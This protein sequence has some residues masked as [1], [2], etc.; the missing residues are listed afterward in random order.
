M[1]LTSVLCSSPQ[2]KSVDAIGFPSSQKFGR[3]NS[4]SLGNGGFST[5]S[6]GVAFGIIGFFLSFIIYLFI[7]F[8]VNASFP[9]TAGYVLAALID[10]Q[11]VQAYG[12]DSAKDFEPYHDFSSYIPRRTD[13]RESR[14][15]AKEGFKGRTNEKNVFDFVP[16]IKNF[17]YGVT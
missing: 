9:P 15:C 6:P 11:C 7:Y 16:V 10:Q 14:R 4:S 3:E 12:F 2:R 1:A 17:E 13:R 8:L 5:P